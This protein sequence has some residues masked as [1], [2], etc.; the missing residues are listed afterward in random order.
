M[1]ELP[2][3]AGALERPGGCRIRIFES[4]DGILVD[5]PPRGASVVMWLVTAAFGVV[6]VM[7]IA[8]IAALLVTGKPI[9]L[10]AWIANHGIT[11]SMHGLFWL[12]AP[13]FVAA[14]VFGVMAL[15][16]ILR[17]SL[18]RESLVFGQDSV[19][20]RRIF[21][22]LLD[23]RKIPYGAIR[24]FLFRSDPEG[25]TS[26]T[27]TMISQGDAREVGEFLPDSDREWLASVGNVFLRQNPR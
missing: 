21:A 20:H 15:L 5:I 25:I 22:K 24:A 14:F 1:T 4:E 6:L 19:R 2:E 18:A 7:W 9:F 27:L 8:T 3:V 26:G 13:F 11:R 23:E 12:I 16:W 10:L 17:P